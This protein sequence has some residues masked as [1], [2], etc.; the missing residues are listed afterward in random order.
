MARRTII[1]PPTP[2]RVVRDT[3]KTRRGDERETNRLTG[4]TSGIDSAVDEYSRRGPHGGGAD[5]GDLGARGKSISIGRSAGL[6][7]RGLSRAG[8]ISGYEPE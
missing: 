2:V 8:T 7:V 4:A 3:G 5:R 1:N 6:L